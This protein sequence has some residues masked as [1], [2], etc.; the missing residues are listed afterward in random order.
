MTKKS[1]PDGPD[2]DGGACWSIMRIL[3]YQVV[4]SISSEM[5]LNFLH[6]D[7]SRGCQIIKDVSSVLY[8][9]FFLFDMWSLRR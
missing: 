3:I 2:P 9:H 6:K 1:R 4:R 8:M 5:C 7:V